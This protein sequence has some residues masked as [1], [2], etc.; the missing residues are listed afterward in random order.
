MLLP[1]ALCHSCL[2]LYNIPLCEYTTIIYQFF[3]SVDIFPCFYKLFW[4]I[5][6]VE[7]IFV[8]VTWYPWV[9][10]SLGYRLSFFFG[11][12][13][14]AQLLG[15][16]VSKNSVWQENASCF[17]KWLHQSSPSMCRFPG[18][19]ILPHTWCYWAFSLGVWSGIVVSCYGLNFHS[20]T[21]D[22]AEQLV[23][24]LALLISSW[25][26]AHSCHWSLFCFP[27]YLFLI[28]L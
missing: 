12:D 21:T 7:D 9:R 19:R 14:G 2:L 26:D 22:K 3:L 10:V 15:L 6:S 5:L 4:M 11:I 25:W 23:V 18:G 13:L 24:C 20:L 8:H 16:R 1:V 17:P 27:V 28:E